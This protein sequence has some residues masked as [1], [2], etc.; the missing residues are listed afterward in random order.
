M[1]KNGLTTGGGRRRVAA[2]REGRGGRIRGKGVLFGQREERMQS[3]GGAHLESERRTHCNGRRK[4][5]EL[6]HKEGK[7]G[8]PEEKGEQRSPIILQRSEELESTEEGAMLPSVKVGLKKNLLGC[9]EEE[10]MS[11]KTV[12]KEGGGRGVNFA[13]VGGFDNSLTQKAGENNFWDVER[14]ER[15]TFSRVT[16]AREG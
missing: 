5:G 10:D 8:I 16:K 11:G 9:W 14:V 2:K 1:W 15:E 13:I 3:W 7:R 4:R 6:F 12:W